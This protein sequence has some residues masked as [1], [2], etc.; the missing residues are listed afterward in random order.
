MEDDIPCHAHGVVQIPL[1]LVQDIFGRSTEK[2]GAGLWI[3]AFGKEG[4]VFIAD[5]GDLEQ[6][7]VRSNV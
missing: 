7:A 5:L 3:L 1:N 4:E 6:A 2:D